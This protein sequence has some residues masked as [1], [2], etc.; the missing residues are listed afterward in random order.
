MDALYLVLG[1]RVIQGVT[2]L[3]LLVLS[4]SAPFWATVLND[5]PRL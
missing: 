4:D 1:L 3:V 5:L 2:Y